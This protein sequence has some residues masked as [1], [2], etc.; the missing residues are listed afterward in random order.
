V[1]SEIAPPVEV[2]DVVQVTRAAPLPHGS[3]LLGKEFVE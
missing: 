3:E 2:D 1:R